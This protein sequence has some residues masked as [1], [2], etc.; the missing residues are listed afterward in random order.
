VTI[1]LELFATVSPTPLILHDCCLAAM[2]GYQE[3]PSS[4]LCQYLD[5]DVTYLTH[6]H[7]LQGYYVRPMSEAAGNWNL[8]S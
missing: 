3:E 6:F 8:L 4:I 1:A 7:S 5:L 2:N